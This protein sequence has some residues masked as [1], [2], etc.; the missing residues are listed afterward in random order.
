[1]RLVLCDEPLFI[2]IRA[3]SDKVLMAEYEKLVAAESDVTFAG[4][5]STYRYIDVDQAILEALG[6]CR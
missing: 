6:N 5:L 4:R 2:Q 3:A 1:M